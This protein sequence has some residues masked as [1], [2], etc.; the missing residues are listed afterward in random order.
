MNE[1]HSNTSDFATWEDKVLANLP[2]VLG[3]LYDYLAD[4]GEWTYAQAVLDA[5]R[6][7]FGSD[8]DS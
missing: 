7:L 2:D 3:N 8:E 4:R 6:L 5:N 1:S